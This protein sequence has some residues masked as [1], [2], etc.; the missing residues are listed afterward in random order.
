MDLIFL[1]CS[2]SCLINSGRHFFFFF[3]HF[4]VRMCTQSADLTILDVR[5]FSSPRC[6]DVVLSRQ[7][8]SRRCHDVVL[9]RQFSS[10]HCHDVVLFRQLWSQC[11]HDV[12][13][14]QF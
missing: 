2:K 13:S 12:L 8:S 7:F 9:S 6:H 3:F 11:R 5:Q 4:Q 14:R 10:R 1:L